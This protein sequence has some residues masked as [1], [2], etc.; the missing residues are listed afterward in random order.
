MSESLNGATDAA[1][2]SR[3][4]VRFPIW[5]KILA[6][7]VVP[8][9]AVA[10]LAY[11]Q[12][13][14]AND[15]VAEVDDETALASVA[16]SPGSLVDALIIERGDALV[17]ML[18]IRETA[19][20]PTDNFDESMAETD[21]AVTSLSGAVD[22]GGQVAQDAFTETLR[23]LEVDLPTIR[24][25]VATGTEDA[26]LIQW[27]ASGAV[28]DSYSRVIDA[29]NEANQ[30]V[31]SRI[32]DPDLRA[33][34]ET[35]DDVIG[36][37][38]AVSNLSLF[39]GRSLPSPTDE[40]KVKARDNVAI[41]LNAYAEAR[42]SL[43]SRLDGPW[44]ESVRAYAAN[45]NYDQMEIQAQEFL[46][47]G[48]I[49]L[50]DYIALN[51][52]VQDKSN[53]DMGTTQMVGFQATK[54]LQSQIDDLRADARD[55]Q[56]RY[57]ILAIAVVLGAAVLAALDGPLG[58]PPA[59]Q[60]H[61]AGRGHGERPPPRGGEAG[62]RDPPGDDVQI[63]TSHRSPVRVP[64][65][66]PDRGRRAQRGADLGTRPRRRAGHA[67]AQHRRLVRQPR[68]PHPEPDRPP[69][70]A[71]H[72][73]R[74]G[75]GRSE[76]ARVALPPRPPRHPGPPQRRV[77][78]GARRHR[79]PAHRRRT[80]PHVRRR[81]GDPQRGRG[82][83]AGRAHQGR[84]SHG[85]GDL[86]ADLIHL[87][88]EL[89]EN[90]LIFSPPSSTVEIRGEHVGDVFRLT[91]ED[92]GVGMTDEKIEEANVR[93]AGHENFTV[94][95]SR[96]LGHYV[97]GRL[98]ARIGAQVSLKRGD[99][100]GILATVRVPSSLLLDAPADA[101][102]AAPS[103]APPRRHRPPPPP[104]LRRCGRLRPRRRRPRRSIDPSSRGNRRRRRL[105]P[106]P[107]RPPPSATTSTAFKTDG[108]PPVA[109][110]STTS[111]GLRR[112]VPGQHSKP[113]QIAGPMIPRYEP[114]TVP[115]TP[116]EGMAPP[117]PATPAAPAAA[118]GD[119]PSSP[120][121]ATL[122]TAYN[123]GLERGRQNPADDPA[124]TAD[125]ETPDATDTADP[126]DDHDPRRDAL[127]PEHTS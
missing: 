43:A 36:A 76:R 100:G 11:L 35:L 121:L 111:T 73:A 46:D 112:R 117:A 18:G 97:A 98:A 75:R 80:D 27:N 40:E 56:R 48:E 125:G 15:R 2:P 107:R 79:G 29:L 37:H 44:D 10:G 16:L 69:T 113:G 94:A 54:G 72:P 55:E 106:R 67:A 65:R 23:I 74:G 8:L 53:P 89:T 30:T 32:S 104:P 47:T 84:R 70:R 105:P 19:T 64:R 1:R 90:G 26:G 127:D 77:A 122:L 5:L 108:R 21:T 28:Y 114:T 116:E 6:A 25:D 60:A 115:A 20:F 41:S 52:P 50:T 12:V 91:I 17:T 31:I 88:A 119:T 22:D 34:G 86:A 87:L 51:P 99:G 110:T 102:A 120:N 45:F 66:G 118:G 13:Q 78:G 123:S 61:R 103:A 71:D 3:R 7:L 95:P 85:A 9:I 82:L 62:A 81:P 57:T 4:R 42:A 49:E 33:A 96:Y 124:G 39:I 63:P 101:P 83:P 126:I 38:D 59:A 58:Q 14:Q 92:Q 109:P 93:L 68:A 24:K